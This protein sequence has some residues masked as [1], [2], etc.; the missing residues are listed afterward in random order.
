VQSPDQRDKAQRVRVSTSAVRSITVL[1][2]PLPLRRLRANIPSKSTSEATAEVNMRKVNYSKAKARASSAI[3][4][5]LWTAA[6]EFELSFED[7]FHEAREWLDQPRLGK[8]LNVFARRPERSIKPHKSCRC[9]L[10]WQLIAQLTVSIVPI[11]TDRH[12]GCGQRVLLLGKRKPGTRPRLPR[13]G[14]RFP[15]CLRAV[16]LINK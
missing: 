10:P 13:F 8:N 5:F 11:V 1:G 15:S 6:T 14:L 7:G 12:G 16:S 2:T 4:L 3:W 9:A